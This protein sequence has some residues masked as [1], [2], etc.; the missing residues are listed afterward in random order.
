ML[1]SPHSGMQDHKICAIGVHLRRNVS[2]HGIG[3]NVATEMGWFEQIEA[4]GLEGKMSTSLELEGAK[5]LSVD[6]V[7]RKLVE[8]LTEGLKGVDDIVDIR[9]ADID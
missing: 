5:G 1:M 6:A 2:S 8:Q 7:S 4:C 9:E 3:L